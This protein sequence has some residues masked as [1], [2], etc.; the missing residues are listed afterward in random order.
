[1]ASIGGGGASSGMADPPAAAPGDA[2]AGAEHTA[3]VDSASAA[4]P[5]LSRQATP[6]DSQGRLQ[7]GEVTPDRQQHQQREQQ[8]AAATAQLLQSADL[9]AAASERAADEGA[10]APAE[11]AVT[12]SDAAAAEAAARQRQALH[13]AE[14]LS[15]MDTLQPPP[16]EPLS[17]TSSGRLKVGASQ[18]QEV[19]LCLLQ[20]S[21]AT[22]PLCCALTSSHIPCAT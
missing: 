13:V 9:D 2:A 12:D 11:D 17:R 22:G 18:G 8:P 3:S 4:A 6:D 1:M 14:D 10:D 19:L 7:P 21:A 15:V 20:S 16:P 5:L